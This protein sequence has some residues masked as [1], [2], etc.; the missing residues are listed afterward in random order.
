MTIKVAFVSCKEQRTS[1]FLD[2]IDAI[3]PELPLWVVSEFPPPAG[4]WIP[5]KP[6][7]SLREN[8]ARLIA[9]IRG[10]KVRLAAVIL[11]PQSPYW[12]MRWMAFRLSPPGFIAFNES[13]DNFMLRPRCAGTIARH[14]GWRLKAFLRFQLRPGGTW[15]TWAWR[16]RHPKALRRPAVY[17]AALIAGWLASLIRR[18]VPARPDPPPKPRP[19]G[20][21]VVI[22]T[23]G[24]KDLLARILPGLLAQQPDEV[25]VVDNGSHD[26]TAA[27]LAAT[28]P[29]VQVDVSVEPLPVG[30]ALNRGVRAARYSHVCVLNNDMILEPDFLEPLRRAFDEV[31]QL[32]CATAQILFPE[33]MRR[34]ET[35]KAVWWGRQDHRQDRDFPVRC[36]EPFA[37]ED[38]TYVLYGSGGCSMYDAAKY[39]QI[40]GFD[41]AIRPAYVEDLDLGWRGWQRNWPTVF[42]ARARLIHFHRSTTTRHFKP[43]MLQS[44]VEFNFLRFL[45]RHVTDPAVFRRLWRDAVKRL[46]L[47]AVDQPV[48]LGWAIEALAFAW[49]AARLYQSPPAPC[50]PEEL[51]LAIGSGAVAVFPGGMQSGKPRVMVVSPY[52]PFPLSH[53]GAVR[54]FNLMRCAAEDFDQVLVAFVDELM[55]APAELL[56]LCAEVVLVKRYPT[57][58]FPDTGRPDVVEEY[59]SPVMHAALRQT[60]RKWQPQVAQLEFTQMAQY[61][62]DCA[63][64]R[65]VLVEHDITFDLQEQLLAQSE[66]WETRRQYQRWL[67]FEKAAWRRMD[68]VVVM[69]G[70]DR[71]AVGDPK[72]V[73]LANGV[74]LDRF[75][76]GGRDPEPNRML[77]IG[78]FAHLPNVLAMDFFLRECWPLLEDLQPVL[79]IIAGSRHRYFLDRYQDTVRLNIDQ[80]GVQIEDFVADVRPAYE[81]A[82]VV[83][84]PL[85]A[86]AG[87]N[88]KIMEAMAMRKAVV[89]TPAGI[90]GLALVHGRDVIVVESGAEMAR[91]IRG[92]MENPSQRRQLEEQARQT[93]ERDFDWRRI[94]RRQ[95]ELYEKLSRAEPGAR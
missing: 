36:I 37:G 93:V 89:S 51:I 74:D 57:H 17:R 79:H 47:L 87:T 40:G 4:K 77:F 15:Y 45:A 21:S 7:R 71:A 32:F 78:S 73:C 26:G 9:S 48:F 69:S 80:P 30:N 65:T 29:Q 72:A 46:N 60:V 58:L 1:A 5:Y 68:A 25:I 14:F 42:V 3:Y 18:I 88:I 55:P 23:R 33:G 66:D 28:F 13:L 61:A 90:N 83:I 16:L 67:R 11:E 62:A 20:I 53:G 52:I 19:S 31:P 63:P 94:G 59:G 8:Y 76:T 85:V 41:E 64:A 43:E 24:G 92:L 10:A 35:G 91:A 86:S 22:P 27:Y 2:R 50:W 70:K 56:A 54:I 49:K 12:P 95:R 6:N 44:F 84:A 81:R 75:R 34:Q 38:K 39:E 82:S